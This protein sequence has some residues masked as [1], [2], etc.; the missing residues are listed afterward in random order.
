MELL[1]RYLTI[2]SY[3]SWPVVLVSSGV[4]VYANFLDVT[5]NGTENVLGRLTLLLAT[6]AGYLL[7]VWACGHI[8]IGKISESYRWLAL[9]LTIV[10]LSVCWGIVFAWTLWQLDLTPDF[11]A[12][13]RIRGGVLNFAVLT[14]VVSIIH[15][16]FAEGHRNRQERALIAQRIS[17]L[18]T[19]NRR[20]QDYDTSLLAGVRSQLEVALDP[21]AQDSAEAT[22]KSLRLAVDEIIRP[23]I[24]A[25]GDQV[26]LPDT[27]EVRSKN[28]IQWRR[29]SESFGDYTRPAI[30]PGVLMFA[31]SSLAPLS[32]IMSL[33]EAISILLA[34]AL[35][36]TISSYILT[37]LIGFL[38]GPG[39]AAAFPLVLVLSAALGAWIF[40][41]VIPWEE[42]NTY[43]P[44]FI[45]RYTLFGIIAVLMAIAV[46]ENRQA[47]ELIAHDQADLKWAA[48]RANEV[49][50]YRN[51]LMASLLHGRWQAVLT[52]AAAR[53]QIAIRDGASADDAVAL[54][55]SEAGNLS[56]SDS[57]SEDKPLS[58]TDAVQ[59][60]ISLWEGVAEITWST[61]SEVVDLVEADPVCARLCGEL[62]LEL[63]MNAIKHAKSTQIAVSLSTLDFRSVRLTVR[64]N[65]EPYLSSN[66]GYG[67]R[68]LDQ[69]CIRW[70]IELDRGDTVVSADL[71]WQV[72][73]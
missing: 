50:H 20:R 12:V 38:S 18:N 54:A 34:V 21:R 66:P 17:E 60:T 52:A 14:V 30:I 19:V 71:P 4:L 10:A 40:A 23:V 42:P 27:P 43:Y 36:L 37:R 61:D 5:L 68:L 8:F 73:E 41:P 72:V 11:D 9:W 69:S 29:I 24:R 32:R 48:A 15:S 7:L 47:S 31:I 6:Q 62:I 26:N 44:A 39:Q 1:R 59:E 35:Q 33:G 45:I 25:L 58:L 46:G 64:N 65:G 57:D 53:L 16:L 3:L 67:S 13:S 28:R 22:L 63:C 2:G 56:L 55:R 51:R 70:S 49:Q